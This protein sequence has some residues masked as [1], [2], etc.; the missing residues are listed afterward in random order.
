MICM[1]RS[2][3]SHSQ[4]AVMFQ[5][6]SGVYPDEDDSETGSEEEEEEEE[7]VE[8]HVLSSP[9]EEEEEEEGEDKL[10]KVRKMSEFLG[11][12]CNTNFVCISTESYTM[13]L[14]MVPAFGAFLR[15]CMP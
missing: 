6:S 4:A 5:Q 15:L 13:H 10:M 12:V 11:H 7:E 3:V 2:R 14:H 9:L 1:F 8:R